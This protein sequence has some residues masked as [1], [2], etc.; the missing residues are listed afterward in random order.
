MSRKIPNVEQDISPFICAED[1]DAV[2]LE[3]KQY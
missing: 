2:Q 3:A 1:G